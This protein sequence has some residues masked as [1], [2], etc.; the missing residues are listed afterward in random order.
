MPKPKDQEKQK[1]MFTDDIKFLQKAV[2]FHPQDAN[3]FLALKRSS[4]S[5]FRPNDWDLVG[6]NVLYGELH[7][8]SLRKEI[9]EE[10]GIEVR[11]LMP[12]QII[13]NY[14]KEKKIYYIFNG[15]Y[16]QAETKDVKISE[17]HSQYRWLT[18]EEFAKLNPAKFLIDLVEEVFKN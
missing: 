7:D 15:F 8:E 12:V 11:S 4:N 16:C 5:F 14:D 18:K 2:V 6:G 3:L 1:Y 9:Q 10:A 13:T 17:E